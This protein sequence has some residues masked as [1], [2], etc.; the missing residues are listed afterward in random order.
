M[1]TTTQTLEADRRLE[2]FQSLGPQLDM[3][4]LFEPTTIAA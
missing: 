1:T 2:H 4:R 3:V